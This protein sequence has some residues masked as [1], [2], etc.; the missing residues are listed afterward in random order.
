V[1]EN[2]GGAER[3]VR[4]VSGP[5]LVVAG[6]GPLKGRRGRPLGL[7]SMLWG[8]VVTET[9]ISKTCSMNALLGRDTAAD[10]ADSGGDSH[11]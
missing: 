5:L 2:V 4:A 7:F 11:W 8:A 6:Y 9:A 1:K 3:T 10:P